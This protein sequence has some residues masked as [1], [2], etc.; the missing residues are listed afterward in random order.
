M[1]PVIGR[2]THKCWKREPLAT[3]AL[4]AAG[5]TGT[6]FACGSPP[7]ANPAT[8]TSAT[9]SVDVY[10]AASTKVETCIGTMISRDAALTAGHCAAGYAS[11]R[12]TSA[13]EEGVA[14]SS[15]AY[16]YNWPRFPVGHV[17]SGS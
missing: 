6:L 9:V 16:T 13:G 14:S 7:A 10:D 15:V 17:A 1:G 2:T 4:G 11:W 5:L 12:V 8:T 3:L